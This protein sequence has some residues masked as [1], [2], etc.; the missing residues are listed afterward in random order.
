MATCPALI[1]AGL[2]GALFLSTVLLINV[3]RLRPLGA[4]GVLAVIPLVTAV[5]ERW[6]ELAG[7]RGGAGGAVAL[8]AGL[9]LLGRSPP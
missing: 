9:V 6:P 7:A 4:A 1:S 3:W 2:I 8:A 5:T